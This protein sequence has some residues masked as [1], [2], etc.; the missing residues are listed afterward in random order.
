MKKKWLLQILGFQLFFTSLNCQEIINPSEIKSKSKQLVCPCPASEENEFLS[1]P[2]DLSISLSLYQKLIERKE[3]TK[4]FD[5]IYVQALYRVLQPY[6][7]INQNMALEIIKK[8]EIYDKNLPKWTI[9]NGYLI[10]DKISP[11]ISSEEERAWFKKT[12]L[13]SGLCGSEEDIEFSNGQIKIKL[14]PG[15]CS[16]KL[17]NLD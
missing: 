9:E 7:L 6:S 1:N 14:Q 8:I 11:Y 5:E 12:F 2:E 3:S 10:A 4:I 15:C 13:S 17:Q 16:S